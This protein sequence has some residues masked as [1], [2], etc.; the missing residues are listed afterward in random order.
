MSSSTLQGIPVWA[1]CNC[2]YR[3]L[4]CQVDSRQ[5]KFQ[6][7]AWLACTMVAED[8]RSG[9]GQISIIHRSGCEN[10]G[11]DALSRNAILDSSNGM[12]HDELF[13]LWIGTEKEK[14]H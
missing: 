8:F 1:K 6:W 2:Y 14:H 11:A 7:Q 3:P 4:C 12:D 13:V 9:V 5:A 10:V